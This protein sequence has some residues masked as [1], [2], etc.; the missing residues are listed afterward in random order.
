MMKTKPRSISDIHL[1]Y[2]GNNRKLILAISLLGVM[3]TMW[4]RVFVGGPKTISNAD[5]VAVNDRGIQSE[6]KQDC[7]RLKYHSLPFIMGRDD[8]L[9]RDLFSKKPWEDKGGSH[10]GEPI[11]CSDDV[12]SEHDLTAGVSDV[13]ESQ[14][15]AVLS[16]NDMEAFI[17]D[18]LHHIGDVL[19][20]DYKGKCYRLK[21]VGIEDESV[22][23]IN[24]K[25]KMKIEVK[26][27]R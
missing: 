20:V 24:I 3:A 8:T 21:I 18:K 2:A 1:A 12:V 9:S 15:K 22:T 23:F 10:G 19:R 26:V 14:L 11:V 27:E 7:L 4:I 16:G 25:T 17:G 5:A 13:L 6:Q